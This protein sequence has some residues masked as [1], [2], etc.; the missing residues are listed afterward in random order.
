MLQLRVREAPTP[1]NG[2]VSCVQP[3]QAVTKEGYRDVVSKAMDE[4]T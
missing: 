3:A 1:P 4:T 2:P